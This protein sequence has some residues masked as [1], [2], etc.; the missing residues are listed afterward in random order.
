MTRTRVGTKLAAVLIAGGLALG[1]AACSEDD[2]DIATTGDASGEDE[3]AG[4]APAAPGGGAAPAPG[5]GAEE[6]GGAEG[7][8][9]GGGAEEGGGEAE[10]GA[11]EGGE[12]EEGG[13]AE[14]VITD[15]TF[16]ESLEVGAG[17][18]ITV[19]NEDAA[20]H[21]VTAEDDSFDVDVEGEAT[22]DFDAPDEAGDYEVVCDI[23]PSME[24][25]ITVT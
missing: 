24:M 12:A 16:P 13:G 18:T 8:E 20:P 15:I 17:E 7:G 10:G 21:T 11:A 6:G 23:H 22:V 25:T 14:L 9:A 3:Q 4:Q 1:A 19:V 2:D 5:A